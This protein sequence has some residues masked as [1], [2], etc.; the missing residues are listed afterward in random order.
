MPICYSLVRYC[1]KFTV[2]TQNKNILLHI[3]LLKGKINLFNAIL[4]KHYK[5]IYDC[6]VGVC[7]ANWT[8]RIHHIY[9]RER[10]I[11]NF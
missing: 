9:I 8:T 11:M 4:Y 5:P 3:I 10:S 6:D 2:T 1:K 7:R